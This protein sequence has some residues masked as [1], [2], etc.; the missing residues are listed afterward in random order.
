MTKDQQIKALRQSLRADGRHQDRVYQPQGEVTMWGY[1]I[2]LSCDIY[3]GAR[4]IYNWNSHYVDLLLDRQSFECKIDKDAT[5]PFLKWLNGKALPWLRKTVKRAKP[6]PNSEE[7]FEL[8]EGDYVLRASCR[9]SYG[10]LYIGAAEL[11]QA[12]V[13]CGAQ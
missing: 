7:V 2:P 8:V 4:A 13:P 9:S 1:N 12:E 6:S 11:N 5:K 3:W 10:Y